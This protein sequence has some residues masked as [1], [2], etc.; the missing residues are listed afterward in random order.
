[1]RAGLVCMHTHVQWNPPFD[2]MEE[3]KNYVGSETTP[4]IN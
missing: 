2:T 3:E 4:Y 1:M